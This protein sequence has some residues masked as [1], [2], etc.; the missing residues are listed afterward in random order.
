[1]KIAIYPGSFDPITNG[2]LDVL[3]RAAS[4]F[5]LVYIAVA[6]N[7]QKTPMFSADERQEMI[8]TCTTEFENVRIDSFD[9]LVVD[10]A[11]QVGAEVIIRGL[12]ALSDFDYEFQMAL[13]NRHL[14]E[15]IDTVFLTP[16]EDYTYLSSSVVREL[17][18]FGG[19]IS[20][21]VP[22]N[23]QVALL[24]KIRRQK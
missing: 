4:L 3:K 1:M 14:D 24:N 17:V 7:L 13:M 8:R 2:H 21:F 20:A 6:R 15:N 9:G 23:V 16:H 10:Y 19:D 22:A 5:D 12:R 18:K 11:R